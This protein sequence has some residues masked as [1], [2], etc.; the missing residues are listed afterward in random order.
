MTTPFIVKD[1]GGIHVSFI[2]TLD[3]EQLTRLEKALDR[4]THDLHKLNITHCTFTPTGVSKFVD[5]LRKNRLSMLKFQHVIMNETDYVQAR[6]AVWAISEALPSATKLEVLEF[7]GTTG[8]VEE[9]QFSVALKHMDLRSLT[10]YDCEMNNVHLTRVV[11]AL[12]DGNGRNLKKLN[13]CAN[14]L[15]NAGMGILANSIPELGLT[16]LKVANCDFDQNGFLAL[17]MAVKESLTLETFDFGS[18]FEVYDVQPLL[19]NV[20][21]HRAMRHVAMYGTGI[22]LREQ[23]EM[24]QV[25]ERLHDPRSRVMTVLAAAKVLPRLNSLVTLLS[26][27]ILR[28]LGTYLSRE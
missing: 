16:T 14:P 13:L 28:L 11:R 15:T 5:I 1:D 21:T 25:L 27:D 12:V 20:R 23:N 4:S 9:S 18:N 17:S 7:V 22:P 3:S 2:E 19:G 24:F 26:V 6:H 8:F 10:I